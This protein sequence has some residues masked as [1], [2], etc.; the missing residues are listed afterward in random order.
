M[1]D[2]IELTATIERKLQKLPRY[3]VVPTHALAAWRIH[4]TT[5]IRGTINGFDLGR[6]SLKKWDHDRWFIDLPE[7]ICRRAS[8]DVGQLVYLHIM[9]AS[10]KLPDELHELIS[11]NT[12]AHHA[13]NALTPGSQRIIRENVAAAKLANTRNRRASLALG[14]RPPNLH[15]QMKPPHRA[16]RKH[17]HD[18]PHHAAAAGAD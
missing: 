8:V 9:V 18:H 10:E 5:T 16:H 14:I 4:Q 11:H 12:K 6:R 3:V 1:H 2:P 7:P 17:P 15:G 13:W